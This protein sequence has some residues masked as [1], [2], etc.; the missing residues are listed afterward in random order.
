MLGK[1]EAGYDKRNNRWEL[2]EENY[3]WVWRKYK[4]GKL[5]QKSGKT[6]AGK[7]DCETDAK[8]HGMDGYFFQLM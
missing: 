8:A 1:L 7:E 4:E 5:I 6:F 2:S 3:R